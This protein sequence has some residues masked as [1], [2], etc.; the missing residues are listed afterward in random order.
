MLLG[1]LVAL[2]RMGAL[3]AVSPGIGL[4]AVQSMQRADYDPQSSAL[5]SAYVSAFNEYARRELHYG[6]GKSFKPSIRT[7]G[8]W[9]SPRDW[10]SSRSTSRCS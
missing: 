1:L 8:S 2:I 5:S 7:F 4:Y 6:D 3:A 10:R 9:P